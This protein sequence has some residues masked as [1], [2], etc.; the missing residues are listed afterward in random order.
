V[1]YGFGEF[2]LDPEAYALRRKGEAID[3][4][5]KVLELVA[6][7]IEHRD[8][9][10]GKHE[11]LTALWPDVHVTES[12]LAWCVSQARKALG[13]ERGSRGPIETVHGR[14]YRFGADLRVVGAKASAV[15]VAAVPA[16]TFV[17]REPVMRALR[18]SLAAVRTTGRGAAHL[19][20]GEAGAGKTRCATELMTEAS[21]AGV[22]VWFGRCLEAEGAPAFWPWIQVLRA[23]A[24]EHG[25][26][27]RRAAALLA[28]LAPA[29]ADA[30]EPAFTSG[31]A[32]SF[33]WVD[34]LVTLL[35]ASGD[36]APR[37][38][39]IDD[40][41][42]AD[43][44]SL[45]V[46]D[47]LVPEHEKH[48]IVLVATLRDT[49]PPATPSSRACLARL[50]RYAAPIALT[51]FER[52]ELSAYVTAATGVVPTAGLVT[53]LHEQTGGN[54][55]FVEE[56][57]RRLDR[58]E[59]STDA[60]PGP[61]AA[62]LIVGRLELRE[63][64]L[65]D[66]LGAA[67]ILGET[68][69]LPVLA[70]M[71]GLPSERVAAWLEVGTRTRILRRAAALGRYGFVHGLVRDAVLARLSS[72][73][74]CEWHRRAG[75]A[76]AARAVDDERLTQLA[77][78]FCQALPGGSAAT[79]VR[80]AAA[81]ARAA[82]QAFAHEDARGHWTRSLEALEFDDRPDPTTRGDLLVGLA[83]SE[84]QL[85]R[86][87]ESRDHLKQAIRLASLPRDG[88][89]LVSAARVLRHSL[90]SHVSIDPVARAALEVALPTLSDAG[91]RATALSLLAAVHGPA[92][93][94]ADGEP[95]AER[96][97]ALARP[98]GGQTLLEALWAR[99]FSLSGPGD[100]GALLAVAGEMLQ[101]DAALGR[102]WWSGEAHYAEFCAHAYRGDVGPRDR[103]LAD[104]G[105][106][107][108]RCRLPE[109]VWHHDKLEARLAF[110]RGEFAAAERAWNELA[111]RESVAGLPYVKW[112]HAGHLAA[113][114]RERR[115]SAATTEALWQAASRWSPGARADALRVEVLLESGRRDEARQALDALP[116]PVAV[117]AWL[118]ACAASQAVAAIALG[119]GDRARAIEA[120]L[121]P[122]AELVVPDV[123]GST[124]GSVSHFLG[125]LASF[126]GDHGGAERRFEAAAA[127]NRAAGLRPAL[128]RTELAHA[129]AL[130]AA[131]GSP[132][133]ARDL[134]ASA[135]ESAAALEIQPL[136]DE[137]ASL[138]RS[139]G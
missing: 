104:L 118:L 132:D 13:Q 40:L 110:Q 30:L 107:G 46:L 81:A 16:S 114:D 28:D 60:G 120:M 137:A 44:L 121:A 18:A 129:R 139:A 10:V 75:E 49:E 61:T 27:G 6:Y 23:C 88:A 2:V 123:F 9:V 91:L 70:A 19:L 45:R 20:A 90:L 62:D 38:L 39:V 42:W 96:A 73:E 136:H 127:R 48:R 35:R 41:Q 109:A 11:L 117:D 43:D 63:P 106:A 57:V 86:R 59:T 83:S 116:A 31:R 101:V 24:L 125:L 52:E 77:F 14:G 130:R 138:A 1:A 92:A 17:G 135:A 124:L 66:A 87:K 25:E 21:A 5:P 22:R 85:G 68:F 36:E 98:I 100:V 78:H 84:L 111:G 133:R 4:Q 113:L 32:G 97:L 76:L 102:S 72:A 51:G 126:L 112:V 99:L 26:S 8:R 119:D 50:S 108:H 131:G 7:L 58:G 12:A 122:H 54:P 82:A 79:A 80:Y 115:R 128:A 93:R 15:E 74:R 65:R 69:D 67:S 95:V 56:M 29:P 94:T 37:V 3:L 33:W 64:G 34:R 55:L 47:L 105:R 71:M 53:R 103:A 134:A 89:L